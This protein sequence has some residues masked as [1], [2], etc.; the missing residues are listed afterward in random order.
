[1]VALALGVATFTVLILWIPIGIC[2]TLYDKIT[3]IAPTWNEERR[4]YD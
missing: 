3:G 2:C 1:M 4:L